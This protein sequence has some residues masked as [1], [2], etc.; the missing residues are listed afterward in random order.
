MKSQFLPSK[1]SPPKH[2]TIPGYFIEP[3]KAENALEDWIVITNNV[4]IINLT[5]GEHS[6]KI[7]KKDNKSNDVNDWPRSITLERNYKELAWLEICA[8]N[9]Q[10]FSYIIRSTQNQAYAG[11]LYI[12]PIEIFFPGKAEKFDVDFSFWITQSEFNNGK[13]R[14]I[15]SALMTW[16]TTDWPFKKDRIFVRNKLI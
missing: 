8:E 15:F 5:R 13:Y 9:K 2:S 1:F 16:L 4:E 3:I 11:C 12:F 6:E 14:Q 10:L 7:G